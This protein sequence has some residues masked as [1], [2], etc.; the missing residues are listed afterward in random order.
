M[1]S[2]RIA[3]VFAL[4]L[5]APLVAEYLLGNIAIDA[6]YLAP[7]FL[8]LYG[9]GAVLVREL[10][11]RAG[12]G[13]PTM[14]L[15]ALAYALIEEGLVTQSLFAPSYFGFDLTREAHVAPLGIGGWWTIYVLSLHTIW[16]ICVP[17]AMVEAFVTNRAREPWLGN[18]GLVLTALLF[19]GGAG[20]NA[21]TT[22]Q[23]ERFIASAWQFAVLIL[24][25]AAVAGAAF[26]PWRPRPRSELPAPR[27]RTVGA[28]SLLLW[29]SFV[30]V[31]WFLADWAIVIA[32]LIF[33]AIFISIVARWSAR[34]GWGPQ[35]IL[36]LAGGALLTQAWQ[37]FPHVPILGSQG[38][39][40]LIGNSVF[41]FGAVVL[42]VA[43]VNK[44]F[45]KPGCTG[46]R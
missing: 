11:R 39:I 19:L 18:A 2:K 22:Y 38:T 21:Y 6:L 4:F 30:V 36:A 34:S 46:D 17:I 15:L 28:C 8:T 3:P 44:L 41:A 9:G 24:T 26:F 40:D 35:H 32:Y 5:L 43:A 25:L 12:R 33:Y 16:S 10:A 7:Y 42:L 31:D 29:S 1:T 13:W 45:A 14:L 37:A 23:Q 27:A 20:L